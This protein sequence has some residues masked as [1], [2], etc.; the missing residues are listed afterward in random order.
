M[1][2]KILYTVCVIVAMLILIR[3]ITYSHVELQKVKLPS[4][5]QLYGHQLMIYTVL[6]G[7]VLSWRELI[8]VLNQKFTINVLIVPCIFAGILTFILPA[9]WVSWFGLGLNGWRILQ[10]PLHLWPVHIIL[11]ILTGVLLVRSFINE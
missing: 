2:K 1:F 6:F 3:L 5:Y 9:Q 8:H 10:Y 11:G 4:Q 7:I